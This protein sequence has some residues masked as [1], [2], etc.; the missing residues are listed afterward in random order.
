M[1]KEFENGFM[2]YRE[3]ETWNRRQIM[4]EITFGGA[5]REQFCFENLVSGV[6]DK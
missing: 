6:V 4:G 1:R 3:T 5:N 2:L